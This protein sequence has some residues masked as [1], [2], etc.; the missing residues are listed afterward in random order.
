MTSQ[1][2]TDTYQG[3]FAGPAAAQYGQPAYTYPVPAGYGYPLARQTNAMAIVSLVLAFVFP[4]V[5]IVLGVIAR[6]QVAERGEDGDGLAL[7]GLIIGIVK[8]AL[9]AVVLVFY[10]V[11]IAMSVAAG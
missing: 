6:R 7:A 9:W 2:G 8:T 5:A 1:P 10:V 3:A 11:L 4:P